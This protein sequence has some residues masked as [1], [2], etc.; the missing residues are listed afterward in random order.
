MRINGDSLEKH[1]SNEMENDKAKN[2]I[3]ELK[4]SNIEKSENDSRDNES[5]LIK[6]DSISKDAKNKDTITNKQGK[7]LK[8]FSKD[9]AKDLIPLLMGIASITMIICTM[10]FGVLCLYNS[11]AFN[12]VSDNINKN[13]SENIINSEIYIITDIKAISINGYENGIYKTSIGYIKGADTY[14]NNSIMYVYKD[15]DGEYS[16][17]DQNIN[18]S[19]FKYVDREF[20]IGNNDVVVDIDDD[21][22]RNKYSELKTFIEKQTRYANNKTT[23]AQNIKTMLI[24]SLICSILTGILWL[25]FNKAMFNEDEINKTLARKES[26]EKESSVKD[27]EN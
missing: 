11:I 26:K 14:K 23:Y 12:I 15:L 17:L 3:D 5:K 6:D 19:K 24:L 4:K 10:V 16:I 27:E 21:N 25:S 13:Y 8:I 7:I 18:T 1:E 22:V 9:T 20:D 2:F